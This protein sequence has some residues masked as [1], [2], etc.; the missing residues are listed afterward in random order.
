MHLAI[1]AGNAAILFKNDSCVM[2]ET[3]GAFLKE[4]RDEDYLIC[5]GDISP[6]YQIIFKGFCI[7]EEGG[8]FTL[9][10]VFTLVQLLQDDKLGFLRGSLFDHRNSCFDRCLF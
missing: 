4:R 3:G 9:A 7:V 6:K 1:S 2:I 10:E 8:I 5:L